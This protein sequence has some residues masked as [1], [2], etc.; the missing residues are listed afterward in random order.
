MSHG[1]EG[2]CIKGIEYLNGPIIFFRQLQDVRLVFLTLLL[3]IKHRGLWLKNIRLIMLLTNLEVL[4]ISKSW[5]FERF[6]KYLIYRTENLRHPQQLRLVCN[7][8]QQTCFISVLDII[9]LWNFG[10]RIVWA[11]SV[12]KKQETTS[13][14]CKTSKSRLV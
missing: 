4:V 13:S 6:W 14:F 10:S 12:A 2:E 9:V 7:S 8:I 11:V 1:G 3:I 5:L